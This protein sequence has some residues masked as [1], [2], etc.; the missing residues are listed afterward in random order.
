MNVNLV[1][2]GVHWTRIHGSGL[3]F[4]ALKIRL[5]ELLAVTKRMKWGQSS[6]CHG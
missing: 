3:A 6:T 1:Q 4:T 5:G 2:S